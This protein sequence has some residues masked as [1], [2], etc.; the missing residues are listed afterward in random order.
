MTAAHSA[1]QSRWATL[2]AI[3][4]QSWPVLISSWAGMAFGVLDTAMTGHASPNDLATM[5]LS[6]AIYISV[7]IGLICMTRS[8]NLCCI[9]F[10]VFGMSSHKPDEQLSIIEVNHGN[11]P[12]FVAF[13]VEYNPV[14]A[15]NACSWKVLFQFIW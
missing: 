4:K 6:I 10:I 7:F 15:Q 9:N 3:L 14:A 8:L 2:R 11:Q 5:A 13:D 12:V 1:P